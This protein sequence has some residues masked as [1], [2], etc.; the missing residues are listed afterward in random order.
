MNRK[1]HIVLTAIFIIT[2]V[3]GVYFTNADAGKTV[4]EKPAKVETCYG[5][6]ENIK[7]FHSRGKHSKVNCSNCHKAL[8][9]HI[10]DSSI[11]LLQGWNMPP[12]ENAIRNNTNLL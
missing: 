11:N 12:A 1:A 2:L 8:D 4:M 6:H 7:D 5:C 3:A 9:K 10:R